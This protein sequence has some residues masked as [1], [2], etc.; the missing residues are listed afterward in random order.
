[1]PGSATRPPRAR[2]HSWKHSWEQPERT[3]GTRRQSEQSTPSVEHAWSGSNFPSRSFSRRYNY[4]NRRAAGRFTKSSG[5][6]RGA[7]Y[8][9]HRGASNPDG[10]EPDPV[11]G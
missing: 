11:G 9:H 7:I 6:S 3:T 8:W 5:G 10:P 2:E 4:H 1:M